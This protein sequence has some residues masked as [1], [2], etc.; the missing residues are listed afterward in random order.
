MVTLKAPTANLIAEIDSSIK[1][2]K[3]MRDALIL[4]ERAEKGDDHTELKG[5]LDELVKSM[6]LYLPAGTSH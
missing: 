4:I 6:M 1:H 3:L 5:A 2:L